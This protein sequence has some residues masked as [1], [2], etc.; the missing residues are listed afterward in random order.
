MISEGASLLFEKIQEK[1]SL[2]IKISEFDLKEGMLICGLDA[3]YKENIGISS[4]IVLKLNEESPIAES[5]FREKIT[6]D[7]VPGLLYIREA[8]LLLGALNKLSV[9]PD[10]LLID[11]HGLAHPRCAGLA[12]IIGLLTDI[13]SIGIAKRSLTGN[14]RWD[15][16]KIGRIE[17]AGECV[18]IAYKT[19]KGKT[20][21]ASIGHMVTLQT[22]NKIILLYNYDEPLPITLAHRAARKAIKIRS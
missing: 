7:Y 12:S 1:L 5:I 4:A 3:A 20:M 9:K 18:G 13:P 2:L 6:Y 19:R 17:V 11:G 8:P 16:E 15:N 10:L 14:V 21:Y 22:I